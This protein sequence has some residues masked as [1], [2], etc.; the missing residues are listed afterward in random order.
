MGL[1]PATA[2]RP[3]V[4]VACKNLIRTGEDYLFNVARERY[5]QTCAAKMLRKEG[6]EE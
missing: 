3:L 1:L 2:L 5:H 4:C 6:E